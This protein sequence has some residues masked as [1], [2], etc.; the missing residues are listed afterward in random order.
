M[1]FD[2]SKIELEQSDLDTLSDV[3]FNALDEE[4][5]TNEQII[6]YWNMFPDNLKLEALKWGIDDTP[7]KE[8]MY[9]WLILNCK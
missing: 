9:L 2:L 4:D 3:I 8:N 6:D 5:L 7:T 1:K